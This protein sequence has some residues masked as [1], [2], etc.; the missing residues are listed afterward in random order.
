VNTANLIGRVG[1]F[2]VISREDCFT[3]HAGMLLVKE[4]ADHLGVADLLNQELKVKQRHRGYSE[5]EAVLGLVYNTVIGGD[6][7]SDLEVLRGDPGTRELIGMQQVIAPTSAGEHLRKFDIGSI[8]DLQRVN[9]LLQLQVRPQQQSQVCTLDLDSSIYEQASKKKEGS[10]KAYNG[11]VGYHPLFAFWD[12]TGELVMS[13]LRR[14]SAYTA[15]KARWFL[16]QCIKRVPEE[17]TKKMRADSGFYSWDVVRWCEANDVVFAI[18]AD[19]T[20]PLREAIEAIEESRWEDLER[21]GVAQVAELRYQA[22][23]WEKEYRYIVKR[24]LQMNKAGELYFRYHVHVTNNEELEASKELEW[25]LGHANMENRIKE[26]K[27]GFGLEKLPTRKFHANWA[28]ILIG[29]IAYNLI[30]WMKKLV[31]PE[32]YQQATIKTIRHQLLNLAG[33]IV[34]SGRRRYL[35]ISDEYRYK[36]VWKYAIEKLSALSFA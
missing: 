31:L 19:Q 10:S 24:E 6:C 9:Q 3:S 17:S 26:H 12:E 29:Q 13:H 1:N 11:E 22:V 34:K 14:G 7:L 23:R 18:T 15:S 25:H 33:K 21:Y 27:S 32:S 35:V 20:A 2:N 5:A 8:H 16:N 28:Y 4:F 30:A 36:K